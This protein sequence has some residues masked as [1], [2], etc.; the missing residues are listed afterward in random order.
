[1]NP[2][3]MIISRWILNGMED[4]NT[5]SRLGMSSAIRFLKELNCKNVWH[6]PRRFVYYC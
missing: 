5:G 6:C 2:A 3:A 4:Y 1:M